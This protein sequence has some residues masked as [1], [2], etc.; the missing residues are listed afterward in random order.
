MHP[1]QPSCSLL[2][3]IMRRKNQ[4]EKN[5]SFPMF[6]LSLSC[7]SF[8]SF[9]SPYTDWLLLILAMSAQGYSGVIVMWS[10][11]QEEIMTPKKNTV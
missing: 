9:I 4:D 1:G 8:I 6:S 5:N 10:C 3:P 7:Y 2:D 11:E